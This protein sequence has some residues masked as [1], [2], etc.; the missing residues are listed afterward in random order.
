MLSRDTSQKDAEEIRRLLTANTEMQVS[1]AKARGQH[2]Q[3]RVEKDQLNDR[4]RS[5]ENERDR[6]RL[7]F[8]DIQAIAATKTAEASAME[9]RNREL[10]EALAQALE[11]LKSSDVAA[12]THLERIVSLE[13]TVQQLSDEKYQY[14]SKVFFSEFSLWNIIFNVIFSGQ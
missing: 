4:L 9:N 3:V 11:R 7:Q 1:L 14:M 13:R 10:E 8:S 5:A 12:Q 2:G 6:L